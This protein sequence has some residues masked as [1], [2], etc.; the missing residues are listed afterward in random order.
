MRVCDRLEHKGNVGLKT[1]QRQ[2]CLPPPRPVARRRQG[3]SGN[4]FHDRNIELILEDGFGEALPPRPFL[5]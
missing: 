3:L 2:S 1:H 5:R 4:D